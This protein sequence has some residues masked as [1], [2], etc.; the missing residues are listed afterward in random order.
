MIKRQFFRPEPM[1]TI[2]ARVAVARENIDAGKL[3]GAMTVLQLHQ[4][5]E[6]HHGWKFDR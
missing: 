1:I 3:D 4:P 5:Q 2:L 6:S